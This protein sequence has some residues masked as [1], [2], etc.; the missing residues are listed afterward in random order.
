VTT[1]P[2]AASPL[3]GL[4]VVCF[5]T[6]DWDTLLPTNKHH[7]MRRFAARGARVLFIETLGTRA[8]KL[9][10]GVDLA[11]MARRLGRAFEGPRRRERRL[12]TLSPLVR[13]AWATTAQR[14]ANAALFAAQ[15]GG[16]VARFPRPLAWVYNPYAVHLMPRIGARRIVYHRVDDLA[17][18]PGADREA[19]REAEAALMARA[20]LILC[21]ER[22]LFD[23]ARRIAPAVTHLM[24]NVG[25]YRHFSRVPATDDARLALLRRLTG[26][27]LVFSG[28]LAPHKVDFAL[29]E[30]TARHHTGAQLVLIGPEWEGADQPAA[31]AALRRL[32]NVHFLGHVDYAILPA[33]LH[34]A[35]VLLIPYLLNE[36]TRA[37]SPLKLFEYL[38]T[39][40]PVVATPLPSLLPYAGA[41]R[42]ASEA[43]KWN[44]AVAAA[45]ADPHE[46]ARGRRALA[47]RHT[48]ERRMCEIEA[49]LAPLLAE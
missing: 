2:A 34:E 46:H 27:R 45:L 41:V 33:F 10:S 12:W 43:G 42:L 35:D 14:A 26:P 47:R 9:G 6:A 18:V 24:P 36:V 8:P 4:P 21:T 23:S 11:R 37:V 44:E 13:P 5:S 31:V 39:G 38:A 1:G 7:L 49:L 15:Y 22:S 20:D 30:A 28:H 25:D 48:W 3:A 16:L 19:L 32:P 40:R 29:L 17:A